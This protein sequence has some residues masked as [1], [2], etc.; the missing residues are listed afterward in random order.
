MGHL[1]KRTFLTSFLLFFDTGERS[2]QVSPVGP[3]KGN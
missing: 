2:V 1:K 3:F